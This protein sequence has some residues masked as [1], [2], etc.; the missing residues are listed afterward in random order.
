M[1]MSAP[2]PFVISTCARAASNS[3]SAER[4]SSSVEY[5]PPTNTRPNSASLAFSAAPPSGILLPFSMPSKP[6][7]LASARQVSSDVSPPIS[8]RSSLDQPIGL[9]P[10]RIVIASISH[11]LGR[12]RFLVFA[13][14]L[15]DFGPR[16]GRGHR[17]VPPGAAR[18]RRIYRIGVEDDDSS[19]RRRP[20]G[21]ERGFQFGDRGGLDS[22]GAQRARVSDE[23]DLGQ[24][25]VTRVAQ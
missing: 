13:S 15:I 3:S 14:R 7:S 21:L 10:S 18:V 11:A 6:A 9:A 12:Q 19:R 23:I 2:A 1:R 4:S 24:N 17:D 5:Q 20:R 22:M 16:R 25:L 8:F